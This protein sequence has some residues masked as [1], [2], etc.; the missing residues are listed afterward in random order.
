M[1][2]NNL[3]SGVGIQPTIVDAKGDLIAATANDAVNRLAVGTNGQV[4]V[5]DSGETTG[6]KWNN[7]GTVGGLVHIETQTFTATSAVNFNNVFSSTYDNYRLLINISTASTGN[8]LRFRMR[9]ATTDNTTSN[10]NHQGVLFSST[11]L[12]GFR[13][14][15]ETSGRFGTVDNAKRSA[16]S[17][18][19][20][21]P[22]LSQTTN[23]NSHDTLDQA[24]PTLRMISGAHNVASEFDGIT[25][26][27]VSGNMTGTC[28]IY[29][30]R[31]S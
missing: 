13:V 15:G 6:L 24:T 29:G 14:T 5:A 2:V 18:D 21:S 4:L 20:F 10:Y 9:L 3:N 17:I 7:P 30:Y 12:T 8:D 22:N 1:A 28:S 16:T 23:F 31:K 27:V 26:L 19:L 11:T 25:I